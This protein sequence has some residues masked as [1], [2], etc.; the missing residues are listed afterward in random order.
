MK[1]LPITTYQPLTMKLFYARVTYT[2]GHKVYTFL[3]IILK[4]I[5]FK[6]KN[7]KITIIDI[8]LQRL[9]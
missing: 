4:C 3:Y 1:I 8:H 6:K 5:R 9:I 2:R 7:G